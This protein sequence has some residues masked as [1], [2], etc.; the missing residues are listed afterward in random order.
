MPR[1]AARRDENEPELLK[2]V[3]RC[4]AYWMQQGPFDGWCFNPRTQEWLLVEVK[5][6]ER[7]GDKNEFTDKQKV[8][9]ADFEIRRIK[10]HI[11][12]TQGDVIRDLG[13][14]A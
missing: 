1:Y 7:E 14:R 13:G 4:G 11:W 12:R 5:L 8:L 2:T 9:L 3:K 6:P 10:L